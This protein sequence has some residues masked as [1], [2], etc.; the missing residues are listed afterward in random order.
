MYNLIQDMLHRE[1]KSGKY[2][3]HSFLFGGNLLVC[4]FCN[5]AV[6][7]ELQKGHHYGHCTK[8]NTNCPQK[9][10][11]RE[12]RII[13]QVLNIFDSVKIKNPKILEWVRKALIESH[14]HETNY[15]SETIFKEKTIREAIG[16][17][18]Q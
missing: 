10:Y 17:F 5:R 7:W 16:D 6:T 15:H 11:V 9:K 18:I 2:K 8:F 1:F 13:E 14:Q 4:G 12:E 3:K